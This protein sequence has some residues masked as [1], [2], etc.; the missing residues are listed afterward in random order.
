M[1]NND[2]EADNARGGGPGR[3]RG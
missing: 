1:S 3:C 2:D